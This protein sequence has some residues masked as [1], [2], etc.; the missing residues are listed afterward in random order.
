MPGAGKTTH[1]KAYAAEN[2]LVL[3]AGDMTRMT[4]YLYGI[5]YAFA[6]PSLT[7]VLV[8][9]TVLHTQKEHRSLRH[10]LL[11]ILL[12]AYAREYAAE[13]SKKTCVIDEGLFQLLLS[14]YDDITI[15]EQYRKYARLMPS[16]KYQ[17]RY[18]ESTAK[19][20]ASRMQN[21]GRIPRA[22]FMNDQDEFF[23]TLERN[24]STLLSFLQNN[25]KCVT[26]TT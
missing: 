8:K 20:R 5:L 11:F 9:E 13:R 1:A 16:T 15:E 18:L 25:Y 17:V 10:K 12:S 4:R 23:A 2:H 22:A 14:T 19:V 7:T 26:F 21:R 24:A 3:V 6:H